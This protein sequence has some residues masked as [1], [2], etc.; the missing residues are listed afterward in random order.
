MYIKAYKPNLFISEFISCYFEVDMAQIAGE[1]KEL[2]W[3]DGTFGLLFLEKNKEVYRNLDT[4]TELLNISKT[5]FF[6]QK[7]KPVNYQYLQGNKTSFGIKIKPKG[8][9]LFIDDS[10]G[11]T[12][13]C[14]FEV[15]II[16][17]KLSILESKIFDSN[18][19][20]EKIAIIDDFIFKSLKLKSSESDYILFSKITGHIDQKKGDIS[21]SDL[22]EE[23]NLN[24]KKVERLFNFYLGV[25]PKTYLRIVRFNNS[26]QLQSQL[27]ELNLTQLG[28]ELGF[29]DQSHFIREFK[30][31]STLTPKDFFRR[32]HTESEETLL[33]IISNKW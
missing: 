20:Q 30:R 26:I 28:N 33:S 10:L 27:K 11:S 8:V 9:P 16:S 24:Y 12:K 22:Y 23:F 6:G 31:F 32:E 15:D 1:S 17:R 14:F 25:T 2:V 4:N 21:L 5:S 13:D 3:P 19:I 18:S 29:Y 7:T